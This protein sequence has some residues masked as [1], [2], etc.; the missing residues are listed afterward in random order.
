MLFCVCYSSRE[1]N[2]YKAVINLTA[3]I[4]LTLFVNLPC[5]PIGVQKNEFIM[6]RWKQNCEFSI[7]IKSSS[8]LLVIGSYLMIIDKLRSV[9]ISI[10]GM[11][12][13]T[14]GLI[15]ETSQCLKDPRFKWGSICR[16]MTVRNV[17]NLSL[18]F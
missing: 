4:I 17:K 7:H 10:V 8:Y 3:Y 1:G 12:R 9:E 5:R 14:T 13:S 2:D 18:H 16:S 6:G 11:Y 15:I